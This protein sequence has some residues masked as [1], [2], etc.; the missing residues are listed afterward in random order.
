MITTL[1]LPDLSDFVKTFSTVKFVL[2]KTRC[3]ELIQRCF[4]LPL[5][6]LRLQRQLD[7]ETIILHR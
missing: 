5:R 1:A 7:K 2:L 3:L 4:H 6:E